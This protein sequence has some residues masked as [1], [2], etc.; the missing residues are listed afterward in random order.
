MNYWSRDW[1]ERDRRLFIRGRQLDNIKRAMTRESTFW[2]VLAVCALCFAAR[3]FFS[4][5]VM[6]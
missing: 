5:G 2:K 6:P 4:P 3:V 1:A